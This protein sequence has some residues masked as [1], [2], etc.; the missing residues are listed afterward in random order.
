MAARWLARTADTPRKRRRLMSLLMSGA[1]VPASLRGLFS[2]LAW[3]APE[4][5]DAVIGADPMALVQY[6][7]TSNLTPPQGARLLEALEALSR[8]DSGF[9]DWSRYRPV[10]LAQRPLLGRLAELITDT[11][12]VF[13]FR[14]LLLQ[15]LEGSPLVTD[16]AASLE[17]LVRREGDAFALRSEAAD[18]L[19]EAEGL[20]DWPDIIDALRG[21]GGEDDIRLAVEIMGH[22]D[23]HR[24]DDGRIAAVALAQIAVDS[25]T[26]GLHH[27]QTRLP[28][29]RIEPLLDA[30]A[31]A[32]RDRQ[33][34]GWEGRSKIA[35]LVHGLLSRRLTAGPVSPKQ[36][37][38]WLQPLDSHHGYNREARDA[39]ST[40]L[41][42]D[43][44]LRRAI[45]K[46]VLIDHPVEPT[47]WGNAW[48]MAERAS[49]LSVTEADAVALLDG[50]GSTDP[51]WRDVV[52]LIHHDGEVGATLRAT[53]GRFAETD[54]EAQAWLASLRHPEVPQ[55]RIED[56]RRRSAREAATARRWATHRV[57]LT[58]EIAAIRGGSFRFIVNPAKAYLK[59]FADMG[60]EATD[61]PGRVEEWLGPEL[62]DAVLEG[63]E[64]FLTAAPFKPSATEI[65]ESHAADKHWEA[66]YVVVAA[67]AE[68][69]RTGRG[70]ADLSDERLMAG[71]IEIQNT[72]IDD[73]AGVPELGGI[74]TDALR[75]RGAWEAAQ[76]LAFTALALM[77]ETQAVHAALARAR[78]EIERLTDM[79]VEAQLDAGGAPDSADRGRVGSLRRVAEGAA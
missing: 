64:A 47:L 70:F 37:W 40:A 45:Q 14:L 29:D 59:L 35:D 28:V 16:L 23:Y 38:S 4:M 24:F 52:T 71:Y 13:G 68:R 78:C 8:K 58:R 57:E 32:A 15:A 36:L 67:L 74:L 31:R 50:L 2:W 75:A 27:L 26:V 60:D 48:R 5:A 11:H 25:R 62:R 10:G 39:I 63:F 22:L 49:G 9:R 54:P 76:R 55:W 34:D 19:S 79:V 21:Q 12:A 46:R 30:L 42:E 3:H 43:P 56:D 51:R 7:D 44:A 77:D 41:I 1:H 17:A 69:V 72:R 66:A 20:C 53:A 73:H 65:A 33:D 18:R 61:G 6:G